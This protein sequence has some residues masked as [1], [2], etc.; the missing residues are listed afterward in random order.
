MPSHEEIRDFSVAL[1]RESGYE[2]V[3]ESTAGQVVLLKIKELPR[4][5]IGSALGH[6]TGFEQ[7]LHSGFVDHRYE[8]S[9]CEG[10]YIVYL[11]HVAQP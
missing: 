9:D 1:E 5:V 11:Q 6:Y 7:C 2:I 10:R 4:L 8:I 3:D